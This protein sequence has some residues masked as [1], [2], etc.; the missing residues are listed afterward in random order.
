MENRQRLQRGAVKPARV[1]VVSDLHC[2]STVALCPPGF[3]TEEGQTIGLSDWQ[4]WMWD[5]WRE[6]IGYTKERYGKLDALVINGD[7]IDGNHPRS[8][9]IWTANLWDQ[10]RARPSAACSPTGSGGSALT[11]WRTRTFP[12]R[13]SGRPFRRWSPR[14]GWRGD[15][16]RSTARSTRATGYFPKSRSRQEAVSLYD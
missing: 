11:S 6:L 12:R 9:E 1:L 5:R 10:T 13:R 15:G 14:A 3:D 4:A 2:G 16:C 7:C 8:I